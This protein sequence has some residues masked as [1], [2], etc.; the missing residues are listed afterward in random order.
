MRRTEGEAAPRGGNRAGP[1]RDTES[2]PGARKAGAIRTTRQRRYLTDGLYTARVD[3]TEAPQGLTLG[4]RVRDRGSLSRRTFSRARNEGEWRTHAVVARYSEAARDIRAA[5][6]DK[7]GER[8][9]ELARQFE[10]DPRPVCWRAADA[11]SRVL[12]ARAQRALGSE[13]AEAD[14]ALRQRLHRKARAPGAA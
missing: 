13:Q 10:G 14:R 6:A 11:P 9:I 8:L 4:V 2:A 7:V 1:E 12:V 5:A 3:V